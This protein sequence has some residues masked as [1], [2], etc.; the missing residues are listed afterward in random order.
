MS[1]LC[2]WFSRERAGS[3]APEAIAA[4]AAPLRRFVSSAVRS[5]SA[6]FGSVAAAG[7]DADVFEDEGQLV[8]VWGRMRF[9]DAEL[10]ALAQRHGAARAVA[11]GYA[12]K[13][14]DV[15]AT[16]SGAFAVAV[17]DGRGGEAMLAI[18]RMG[19]RPLSY[20]VTAGTL[21]F[22]STLDAI[23]SFPANTPEIDHQAIYDYMHFHM[24]PGP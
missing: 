19:T 12:R 8:A 1:G 7:S 2:G 13:G 21:V 10:A 23:S 11:Q 3:A 16:L 18:D 6:G 14:P 9:T 4:M 5:G 15:L 24:V 22:G 20:C 17:L